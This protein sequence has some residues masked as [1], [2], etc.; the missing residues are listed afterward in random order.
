MNISEYNKT[1]KD[2]SIE[3]KEEYLKIKAMNT[4]LAPKTIPKL[5]DR[6]VIIPRY[7][8]T[9]FPPLKFSHEEKICP[10]KQVNEKKK[11]KSLKYV[12]ETIIVR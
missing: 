12:K 10:T 4:Q 6:A 8:A 11:I 3:D 9:P 1:I 5:K 2:P 7:V